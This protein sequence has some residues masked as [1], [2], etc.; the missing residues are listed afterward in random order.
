MRGIALGR[1]GH[2]SGNER[3]RVSQKWM[4][5][6]KICDEGG[7][8]KKVGISTEY[9]RDRPTDRWLAGS[10]IV[11]LDRGAKNLRDG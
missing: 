11:S 5:R 6:C 9:V 2:A 10:V 7:H 4:P 1:I 3:G 8:K